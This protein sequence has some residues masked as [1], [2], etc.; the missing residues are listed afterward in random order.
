MTVDTPSFS[1]SSSVDDLTGSAPASRFSEPTALFVV[2]VSLDG[3]IVLLMVAKEE[4]G[5][6]IRLRTWFESEKEDL[7]SS[8][9]GLLTPRPNKRNLKNS[10]I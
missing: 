8:S 5:L 4:G 1:L 7:S 3:D 10:Y 6:P 2:E 9:F